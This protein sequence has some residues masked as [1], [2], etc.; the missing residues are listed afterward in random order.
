[1]SFMAEIATKVLARKTSVY[2]VETLDDRRLYQ[3]KGAI[4]D[5]K[6]YG[7]VKN[8]KFDPFELAITLDLQRQEMKLF[9]GKEEQA[10]EVDPQLGLLKTLDHHLKSNHTV[11]LAHWCAS[12]LIADTIAEYLIAWATDPQLDAKK[13]MFILFTGN[14]ELF[15]NNIRQLCHTIIVEPSSPE[16]REQLLKSNAEKWSRIIEEKKGKPA[17]V[18]TRQE[19]V[20][21]SSGLNLHETETASLEDLLLK[22][23]Y[24]VE[25]FTVLKTEKLRNMNV[26]F[27]KCELDPSMFGGYKT[28]MKYIQKRII[29]PLK[30]PELAKHYAVELPRGIVLFGFHGT[31]KSTIAEIIGNMLGLPMVKL[32]PADL[33][34]G[35]V[36]E[37][38]ATV[39]R[40]FRLIRAISPC[41]VFI[42]EWDQIA[43]KREN[44]MITD[45]GVGRRILNM[46]MEELADRHRNYI[47]IVATNLLSQVDPASIRAGRFD[48][49][50]LMLPPDKEA[51]M[52]II[53][54]HTTKRRKM[55]V[56]KLDKSKLADLTAGFT[57]GEIEQVCKDASQLA[58]EERTE[59]V[60]MSHF[61]KAIENI[62]LNK[63]RRFK[64]VEK[65]ID[66]AKKLETID[67]PML[68]EVIAEFIQGDKDARDRLAGVADAI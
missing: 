30:D 54:I 64:D 3:L 45:S 49:T 56:G 51:R 1:M 48:R 24:S 13:S 20:Q 65:M 37:S 60:E 32:S 12:Q 9:G 21:A 27:T 26:E 31:G 29:I 16:E 15:S 35:I 40:I 28:L 52:E 46:L 66:D 43:Q 50:F 10:L 57:G 17:K 36:G 62:G 23:K 14:A 59:Y 44:V 41:I 42:D 6:F 4:K 33:F 8:L 39:R 47:V 68:K 55:P 53:D 58:M 34:K 5:G 19:H 63:E 67:K 11:V 61:E 25:G 7:M 22:G 38:E 18:V 2:I